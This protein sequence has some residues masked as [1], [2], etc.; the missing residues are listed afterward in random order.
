VTHL[1]KDTWAFKKQANTSPTASKNKEE[2]NHLGAHKQKKH[3]W[4]FYQGLEIEND[5]GISILI[6]SL[7]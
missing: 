7:I 2:E 6:E 4:V 5:I 1:K 3:V